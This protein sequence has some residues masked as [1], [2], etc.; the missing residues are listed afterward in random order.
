MSSRCL[1]STTEIN[2]RSKEYNLQFKSQS[3]DNVV[4]L[5]I[6]SRGQEYYATYR[7]LVGFGTFIG[8]MSL[9]AIESMAE[10]LSCTN[11]SNTS[12]AAYKRYAETI[13]YLNYFYT[14]SPEDP[15]SL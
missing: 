9:L 5:F 13:M 12:E 14:D 11:K 15:K 3:V 7:D 2:S 10:I 4:L 6:Y 1:I 8:A